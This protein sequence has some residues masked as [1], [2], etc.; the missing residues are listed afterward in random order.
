T[1][2]A[3]AAALVNW[4][5]ERGV[6]RLAVVQDEEVFGRVLAQQIATAADRA[7]LPVTDLAEPHDDPAT[8]ADFAKKIAAA[9]P[10]PDAIVYTGLGDANSGPLLTALTRA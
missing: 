3:Q 6:K 4:A 10:E 7:H 2:A 9:R 1:D 5:R 8:F